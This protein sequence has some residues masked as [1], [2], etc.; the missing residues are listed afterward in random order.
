[1]TALIWASCYG[2]AA[3]AEALLQK[4]AD[5]HATDKV[6]DYR[7][8]AGVADKILLMSVGRENSSYVG[9]F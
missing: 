2:H 3:V 6:S 4:G 1:M 5:P 8:A 9:S 7:A